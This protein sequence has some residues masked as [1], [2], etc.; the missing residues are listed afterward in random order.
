MVAKCVH[1]S[2]VYSQMPE[3]AV[4]VI[5]K[6]NTHAKCEEKNVQCIILI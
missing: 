1:F 6:I 5:R 3:I 4:H 2:T